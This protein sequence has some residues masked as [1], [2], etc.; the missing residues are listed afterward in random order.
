MFC[1]LQSP[2]NWLISVPQFTFIGLLFANFEMI[3]GVLL[4]AWPLWLMEKQRLKNPVMVM[5]RRR[6]NTPNSGMSLASPLN[7][8][9]L[10][11]QLTGTDWQN[12][13]D[14]R[15][16]YFVFMYNHSSFPAAL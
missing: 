10:R 13:S 16:I 8:V 15:G 7:L 6:V 12:F 11:M 4:I 5:M 1:S 9:L 2:V 14:L 3:Y